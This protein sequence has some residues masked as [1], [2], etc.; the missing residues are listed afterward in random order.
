MDWGAKHCRIKSG[1]VTVVYDWD[2]VCRTSVP[3]VIGSAAANFKTS[4]YVEG[5]N[6]PT[7]QEMLAFLKD[8]ASASRYTFSASDLAAAIM[9]S[10]AYGARCEHAIEKETNQSE[11]RDFLKMLLREELEQLIHGAVCGGT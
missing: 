10:A 11:N 5:A 7:L 9:Y 8:C 4:W 1:S 6:R 2:S 3:E